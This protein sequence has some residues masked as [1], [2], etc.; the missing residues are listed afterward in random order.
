MKIDTWYW[1][2]LGIYWGMPRKWCTKC[3]AAKEWHVS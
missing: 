3:A 2:R 1:A